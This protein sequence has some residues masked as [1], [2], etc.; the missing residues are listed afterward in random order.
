MINTTK[1][2]CLK[3]GLLKKNSTIVV[4]VSG[5]P[6]SICLLHLLKALQPEFNLTIIAAHLDH[7]WRSNSADDASFCKQFA[8]SMA[9]EFVQ[10][11]ASAIPLKRKYNGS[12][13]EVGR[14]V[15]RSFF[16]TVAHDYGADAIALAHHLDDQQETFFMR[17]IRGASIAG[18]AG[19][20]PLE[21]SLSPT[22]QAQS[23]SYI[24][25]LLG[26]HKQHILNYLADNNL[27]FVH[28]PTNES[29][30]YLRNAL[31]LQALPALRSCDNRFNE[32]FKKT[33]AHLQ[34]AHEF[35][36]RH[37]QKMFAQLTEE[38]DGDVVLINERF[39]EVDPFL[40]DSLILMWLCSANVSFTP[41]SGLFDEIVRFLKNKSDEHALSSTW[42]LVK[43]IDPTGRAITTIKKRS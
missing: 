31:R 22:R 37:T 18:L 27:S 34:K 13:E 23:Y 41:S 6:D 26:T 17:L 1:E 36:D 29:L 33:H 25:P 15:R 9:L 16:E 20:K 30:A 24:R 21:S 11:Q 40:H 5:G 12:Q 32:N 8:Q 42:S 2:Y 38:I 3:H 7:E 43:K 10:D 19:M 14:M 35:I 39:F 28:D 4:G